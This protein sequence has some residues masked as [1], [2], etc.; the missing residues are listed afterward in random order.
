M[1]LNEQQ[2]LAGAKI[3]FFAILFTITL[4]ISLSLNLS[5]ALKDYFEFLSLKLNN[6]ICLIQAEREKRV[7]RGVSQDREGR[8]RI[9]EKLQANGKKE[10]S[11]MTK[12][13]IKNAAHTSCLCL[14]LSL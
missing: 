7:A 4:L 10:E 12:L 6:K 11:V 14:C 8:K 1:D 2:V 9:D 3:Y 13:W 5:I